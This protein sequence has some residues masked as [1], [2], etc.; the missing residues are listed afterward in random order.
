Y[1]PRKYKE[2]LNTKESLEYSILFRLAEQYLI[3]A[4]ARVHLGKIAKAQN[5]L[6]KIRNRAGLPNTIAHTEKEL[7]EA[8]IQE[9][10]I[11]L[12]TEY[13]QR[14]FDL[15]R[16]HKAA[17]ALSPIKP[18]WKDTDI[19]LPLPESELELNPNLQPQ[20]KGY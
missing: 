16:T 9:R 18:N 20:N 1:F 19:L 6:N 8:I 17:E 13:G 2:D 11:E 4:E 7:V 3:R 15:K 10:Q 5:D 14:W 12:F